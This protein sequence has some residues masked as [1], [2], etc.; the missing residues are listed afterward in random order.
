V[1]KLCRTGFPTEPFAAYA[2]Q[3]AS[4]LVPAHRFNR[5]DGF[6]IR[7]F[8]PVP[9]PCFLASITIGMEAI[10]VAEAPCTVRELGAGGDQ[11]PGQRKGGRSTGDMA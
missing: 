7:R 11:Q 9:P 6:D 1:R 8:G 4:W 5:S 2:Y 3:E 10:E